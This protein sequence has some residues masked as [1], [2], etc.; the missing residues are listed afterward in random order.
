MDY[1]FLDQIR[2]GNQAVI[3]RVRKDDQLYAAKMF[4]HKNERDHELG[5]LEKLNLSD[6]RICPQLIGSIEA[7][8]SMCPQIANFPLTHF[9]GIV[10][11]LFDGS[12]QDLLCAITSEDPDSN[13]KIQ[14]V[15]ESVVV[16]KLLDYLIYIERLADR[17]V[18]EFRISH[19]DFHPKNV[20][21]RARPDESIQL[22]IADF[23]YSSAYS[24]TATIDKYYDLL[25]FER[26]LRSK[27]PNDMPRICEMP[28]WSL[29]NYKFKIPQEI[30][31]R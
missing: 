29:I 14:P 16:A 15:S 4:Y 9:Y 23:G 24:D 1:Q 22:V 21:Y 18:N 19:G 25:N 28:E 31:G 3:W 20:L 6:D 10:M 7:D 8:L 13:S 26:F 30:R 17:M 27:W 11:E 2:S 12:F 5:I